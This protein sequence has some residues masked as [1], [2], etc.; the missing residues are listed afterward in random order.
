[1]KSIKLILIGIGIIISSFKK[2]MVIFYVLE[3][4]YTRIFKITKRS[5]VWH[6][7]FRKNDF[8]V[9]LKILK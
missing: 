7:Y 6:Y 3:L 4:V 8:Y 2:Y 1:M 9:R 5:T